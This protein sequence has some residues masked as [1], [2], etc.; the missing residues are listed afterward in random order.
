V[1]TK[2]GSTNWRRLAIRSKFHVYTA[3]KQAPLGVQDLA[4]LVV[5][6]VVPDVAAVDDALVVLELGA[7]MGTLDS[8]MVILSVPSALLRCTCF[9]I[10]LGL[11]HAHKRGRLGSSP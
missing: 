2:T 3:F 9:S 6:A 11:S 5:G 7:P 10:V 4:A 8:E 1:G